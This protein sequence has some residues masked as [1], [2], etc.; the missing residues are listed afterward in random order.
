MVEHEAILCLTSPGT[1]GGTSI[2][3]NGGFE[4]QIRIGEQS[5]APTLM[6]GTGY[7]PPSLSAIDGEVRV[8]QRGLAR[9]MHP[10]PWVLLRYLSLTTLP[11]DGYASCRGVREFRLLG[12]CVD[13]HVC[14]NEGMRQE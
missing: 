2:N 8:R 10:T 1:G 5:S 7:A 3:Y 13:R 4:W 9:R 14:E 12:S 11:R 6:T